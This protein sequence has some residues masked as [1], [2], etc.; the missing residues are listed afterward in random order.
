MEDQVICLR[1]RD[2]VPE[3]R[4]I[5]ND[6]LLEAAWYSKGAAYAGLQTEQRRAASKKTSVC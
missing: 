1:G 4:V 6:Q 3:Y 2:D 5:V